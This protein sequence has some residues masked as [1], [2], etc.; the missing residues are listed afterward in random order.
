[1]R[2]A[3]TYAARAHWTPRP[4]W[5]LLSV[6]GGHRGGQ[7]TIRS[8]AP[9]GWAG[10]LH[11]RLGA[12]HV[13][14]G[15]PPA[16]AATTLQRAA[17]TVP[18]PGPALLRSQTPASKA[19]VP[20]ERGRGPGFERGGD[21]TP[22]V[23]HPPRPHTDNTRQHPPSRPSLGRE[24]GT[25]SCVPRAERAQ[26]RPHAAQTRRPWRHSWHTSAARL[27][28][29]ARNPGVIFFSSWRAH[30]SLIFSG[31]LFPTASPEPRTRRVPR[32]AVRRTAP[33]PSWGA[34]AAAALHMP[35]AAT[36]GERALH[37]RAGSP[38]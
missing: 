35:R 33:A 26:G 32:A 8:D 19:R 37:P 16:P 24:G 4:T 3:R 36:G 20:R 25:R 18:R 15:G 5:L 23:H 13:R 14:R 10:N 27:H 9:L 6:A 2:S 12:A 7:H 30:Y 38:G 29:A 11:H 21:D 1:M 17:R 28:G 22:P 34:A 31:R